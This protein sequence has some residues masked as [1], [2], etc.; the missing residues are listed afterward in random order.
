MIRKPW[1]QVLAALREIHG[2]VGRIDQRLD[3]V[4]LITMVREPA[5]AVAA[6][7][8]EGLRKQVVTSATER[9]AHLAQLAQLDLALARGA[10]REVLGTMIDGWLAHSALVRV[11]EVGP[12][13]V[14]LFFELVEDLGGPLEVLEP[15]YQDRITQRVVRQGRARRGAPGA[16]E[17][18]DPE[19]ARG[20]WR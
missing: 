12:A 1:Q 17:P 16:P 10:D 7:A 11:A 4:E 20:Q 18:A 5:S 6:D 2:L 15:A 13:D 19:G 3:K 9:W 8:Y 14:E